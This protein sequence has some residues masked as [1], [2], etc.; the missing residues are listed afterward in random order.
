MTRR[1]NQIRA[2][3]FGL[4]LIISVI[5]GGA[6]LGLSTTVDNSNSLSSV[7]NDTTNDRDDESDNET[8]SS[9]DDNT[10]NNVS[11]DSEQNST[12]SGGGA[13]DSNSNETD[14]S[15]EEE[16]NETSRESSSDRSADN[17]SKAD[18]NDTARAQSE[19]TNEQLP[20]IPRLDHEG[21]E[22]IYVGETVAIGFRPD[23]GSERYKWEVKSG[24]NG[25]NGQLLHTGTE[26]IEN[27]PKNIN[28]NPHPAHGGRATSLLPT[29]AGT[30]T[31]EV[32]TYDGNG[33]ETTYTRSFE[34]REEQ[35]YVNPEGSNDITRHELAKKYA[36]VIR[37]H[38]NQSF[39]PTRHE[40]Y[41][42]N[43]EL[44]TNNVVILHG[45]K[46]DGG[47]SLATVDLSPSHTFEEGLPPQIRGRQATA[48]N[49]SISPKT[50]GTP[51]HTEY[52]KEI[53]SDV[54]PPTVYSSVYE[55]VNYDGNS[56]TAIG[57]WLV[58]VHD[59]KP[60]SE[61]N[62]N[63]NSLVPFTMHTGDQEPLFILINDKGEPRKVVTQQH[64]GGEIRDWENI[65]TKDEQPVI[66]P[67]EGA[68]SNFLGTAASRTDNRLRD[69]A[70]ELADSG[71]YPEYLYQEQYVC[72]I[73]LAYPC[74]DNEPGGL[75][76]PLQGNW[77]PG[78][79]SRARYGR[80]YTDPIAAGQPDGA[81]Y[82]PKMT[83]TVWS[84]RSN[85]ELTPNERDETYQIAM[86][87]G[88][89]VWGK[90]RGDLY[91][92]PGLDTIRS[93]GSV[94]HQ[95]GRWPSTQDGGPEGWPQL[96]D[97]G[98]FENYA[99]DDV[100]GPSKSEVYTDTEQIDSELTP[101]TPDG[102]PIFGERGIVRNS[103]DT[104]Q[105]VKL[106][107]QNTG[108]QPHEFVV[109]V[110]TEGADGKVET[111]QYS[112]FT[113]T[114]KAD[115]EVSGGVVPEVLTVN[116]PV[117]ANDGGGPWTVTAELARYSDER[118]DTLGKVQFEVP[119]VPEE[120]PDNPPSPDVP[121]DAG[122]D[123][124]NVDG[125]AGG[126]ETP[127][128]I[129]V[130][131]SVDDGGFFGQFEDPIEDLRPEQFDITVGEETV[132]SVVTVA[133]IG[134]GEYRLRFI[135]PS[136]SAPGEYDVR[137]RV[138]DSA[139][140]VQ[141]DAVRYAEGSTTQVSA[142]LQIDRS[143]SMRGI[144]SEAKQGG[145]T[146]VEQG[147]QDDYISVVSY[148]SNSRVDRSLTQLG[149]N[150][151]GIKTDIDQI[152]ASG[153]T[154]IGAA[155]SDGLRTLDGSPEGAETAGIILTDGKLNAGPSKSEILNEIV[156]KYNNRGICLYAI[157]FTDGADTEFLK[158]LA[159]EADCGEYRFAGREGEVDS[160]ENT[161]QS[162]F[163]QIQ[164]DVADADSIYG[165][166]G[167]VGAGET[168]TRNY[169]V[170]QTVVQTTVNIR[171][172]AFDQA[173]NSQIS[174]V[175][176][177]Q[178]QVMSPYGPGYSRATVQ[179]ENTSSITLF[180]P[181]GEAVT[182]SDDNV[183]VSTLDET[184]IYRIGDPQP[185]QWSY[186]ISNNDDNPAEY[187]SR[188]SGNAQ[189]T[190]DATTAG[191]VY[192]EG[193]NTDLTATLV[194]PQG[195][196]TGGNV[197]AVITNADGTTEQIELAEE[198]PGV[199]TGS[200]TNEES[201]TYEAVITANADDISRIEELSWSV[202]E[203]TSESP[204]PLSIS[205]VG[206]SS[207]Q[208][209]EEESFA[210]VVSREE[211]VTG[212]EIVRIDVSDL[213]TDGEAGTIPNSNI[214][215]L[216]QSVKL[217]GEYSNATTPVVV[218]VPEGA[219]PGTYEGT[220]RAFREDGTVVTE[221]F[222][223]TVPGTR[224]S[225]TRD[226]KPEITDYTVETNGNEIIV[227]FEADENLV[228]LSLEI[229]G[230]EDASLNREDFSG[231][232]FE[233]FEARYVTDEDGEYTIELVSAKDASNN[234]GAAGEDFRKMVSIKTGGSETAAPTGDR[235]SA[236]PTGQT[237]TQTAIDETATLTP[238]NDD[239]STPTMP[240]NEP[241]T[242]A[243]TDTDPTTGTK[244]ESDG[245]GFGASIAIIV[246]CSVV[247][248]LR[249]RNRVI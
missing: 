75:V 232:E 65:E 216:P 173:A 234:D 155:M 91:R 241:A 214:V 124:S 191:D 178:L 71:R 116:I 206:T 4:V 231:D 197:D 166:S 50:E 32:T 112:I 92:Y 208:Q 140:D 2:V 139:E 74:P 125:A 82:Q 243:V 237:L 195:P 10:S 128:A 138:D 210:F 200:F 144:I 188:I 157:G 150:R 108:F 152:S 14:S 247:Y 161:L 133:D 167:T 142:S 147:K 97:D 46:Y 224:A 244:T 85:S 89:E 84:H 5:A 212:T 7:N 6:T 44:K 102:G 115:D 76:R 159:N 80:D 54:Y 189:T 98:S 12:D 198:S 9:K 203:V 103:D 63:P 143:G 141:S 56:Y 165:D 229:N 39:Y 100:D 126:I 207:V 218:T 233:G 47:R 134:P 16:N 19:Q 21:G 148:S 96:T 225:Q 187:E 154:N 171:L 190:L 31:I 48:K 223:L 99:D 235:D 18:D 248:L 110:T 29:E 77:L 201:G 94:P 8:N 67:A 45:G 1:R 79:I 151:E 66:Y 27:N 169:D 120:N 87:S 137:V 226:S 23:H 58:Y 119:A 135:A 86:L 59:P 242:E 199:Y 131:V 174:Q 64:R 145:K 49:N 222:N 160:I 249:R 122:V 57:Y 68:H 132:D 62:L 52:Q 219:V 186:K 228:D 3:V 61:R 33:S 149:D 130:D 101:G 36:P 164:R 72:P 194:G 213:T 93:D 179:T 38:P 175:G 83:A 43:S 22:P 88:N 25:D 106:G 170:D 118:D 107:I 209:G 55:D 30:Y 69:T 177:R 121:D 163:Q 184:I 40:A 123:I 153:S 240:S 90:Y 70:D 51:E 238:T 95:Q 204:S 53:V 196:V 113:N 114:G 35:R 172:E 168:V 205:Q 34:V 162:V 20:R 185:G 41:F 220:V 146:F 42:E 60:Q 15:T 202:K 215:L 78:D 73:G 211:E 156:P 246:L 176:P 180:A 245:P 230:P 105:A 236:T 111:E 13:D 24:G 104:P 129:S 117:V 192:Y 37:F 221:S 239:Q 217:D 26:S 183:N 182:A 28:G 127:R 11:S 193:D 227:S 181:D 109:T 81:E 17:G 136:Q 158:N